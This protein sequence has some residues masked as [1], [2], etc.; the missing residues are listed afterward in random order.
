M[1]NFMQV[2]CNPNGKLQSQQKNINFSFMRILKTLAFIL[3]FIPLFFHSPGGAL[4]ALCAIQAVGLG[5]LGLEG[6]A[7]ISHAN[8]SQKMRQHYV[9]NPTLKRSCFD[10]R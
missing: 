9:E 4:I 6:R 2:D 3:A 8:K 5:R 7:C 10:E 1:K